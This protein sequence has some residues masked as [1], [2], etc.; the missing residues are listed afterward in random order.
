MDL[1]SKVLNKQNHTGNDSQAQNTCKDK[2]EDAA[3]EVNVQPVIANYCDLGYTK[4]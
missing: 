3:H 1:V 2:L 4:N